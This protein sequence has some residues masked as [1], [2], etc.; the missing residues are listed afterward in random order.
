MPFCFLL[1]DL[2]RCWISHERWNTNK[3]V[4]YLSYCDVQIHTFL[5]RWA[6]L[7]LF[8]FIF[9][10]FHNAMTNK[11]LTWLKMK[12]RSWCAW[13]WT[14][15]SRM[16]GNEKSTELWP[17]HT[18][19]LSCPVVIFVCNQWP[20]DQ[21]IYWVLLFVLLFLDTLLIYFWGT[22]LGYISGCTSGLNLAINLGP[23]QALFNG[24]TSNPWPLIVNQK[25]YHPDLMVGAD[26]GSFLFTQ[27]PPGEK[28]CFYLHQLQRRSQTFVR[29]TFKI[30]FLLFLRE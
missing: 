23:V 27:I 13:K 10:S 28:S 2:W 25:C 30:L 11:A 14:R 21:V 9:C 29:N 7:G 22:F 6:K 18:F 8:L 17:H 16:V 5:K 26:L 15:G 24:R 12:K 19:I 3:A 20:K 1:L 4:V